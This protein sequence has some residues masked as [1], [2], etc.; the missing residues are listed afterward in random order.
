MVNVRP[1][2]DRHGGELT[3]R[4]DRFVEPA[5]PNDL[6]IHRIQCRLHKPFSTKPRGRLDNV[7][8][9]R[10]SQNHAYGNSYWKSSISPTTQSQPFSSP[11]R[12]MRYIWPAYCSNHD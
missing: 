2:K 12:I 11:S 4:Q 8:P 10:S 9:R 6:I 5:P 1:E 3:N 7:N